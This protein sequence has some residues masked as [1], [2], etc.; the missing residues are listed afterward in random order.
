MEYVWARSKYDDMGNPLT[1]EALPH[2][3]IKS[4]ARLE[5]DMTPFDSVIPG[6]LEHFSLVFVSS[7]LTGGKIIF[8]SKSIL[9][10]YDEEFFPL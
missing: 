8:G 5:W 7:S 1:P 2:P 9:L 3:E 4:P 10:N 6:Y